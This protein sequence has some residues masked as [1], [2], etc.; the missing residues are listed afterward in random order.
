MNSFPSKKEGKFSSYYCLTLDFLAAMH[1]YLR[2]NLEI[3]IRRYMF[4]INILPRLT[5]IRK[6]LPKLILIFPLIFIISPQNF[7]SFKTII[8]FFANV[9]LTFSGF[10]INDVEDADDDCHDLEKRKRNPFASGELTKKQGYLIA[11]SLFFIGLSLLLAISYL[12]FLIGSI[13]SLVGFLYSWRPIRLK[14]IPIVDL[15]SHV[16]G[17]GVLQFSITYLAFRLL[18]LFFISFLMMIIPFSIASDIFQELRDF[19][20]DKERG[21]N[22]TVQKL[23]KFNPRKLFAILGIIMVTGFVTLC[24][25]L[26]RG[27]IFFSIF[28][29]FSILLGVIILLKRDKYLK[30]YRL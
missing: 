7:F 6:L 2:K 1:A 16:I 21:V 13:L 17:V 18:D 9:F 12:V 24:S 26:D 30:M 5:R 14:S 22:N 25:T 8:V 3:V 19:N 29:P 11:F 4:D 10:T 15:I 27:G 23:G 20:V 28:L